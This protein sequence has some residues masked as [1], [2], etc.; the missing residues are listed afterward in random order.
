MESS[1]SLQ[2]AI[3]NF[4]NLGY[5]HDFKAESEGV[6]CL[7]TDKLYPIDDVEIEATHRDDGYTNPA[8]DSLLIAIKTE[9]GIKGTL[10][11]SYGAQHSQNPEILR[12]IG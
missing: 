9:D 1:S 6:R 3:Q 11:M 2:I 10:L 12:K 8:D 7:Q 4:I 5:I